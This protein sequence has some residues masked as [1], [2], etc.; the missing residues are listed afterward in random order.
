MSAN[1]EPEEL[2]LRARPLITLNIAPKMEQN[3]IP[4]G[5]RK[6]RDFDVGKVEILRSVILAMSI[7]IRFVIF[8]LG[9]TILQPVD[10]ISGYA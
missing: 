3:T 4:I 6:H 8:I 1:N 7:L 5:G 2:M 10:I 9:S